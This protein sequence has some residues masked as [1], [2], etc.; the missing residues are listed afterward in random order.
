MKYPS[1]SA[2]QFV[3]L[4]LLLSPF[5]SCLKEE[6]SANLPVSNIPEIALLSVSPAAVHNL[7]DSLL[8]TMSYIDGDGDLGDYDVDSLSLWIT[9]NRFPLTEKFHI[10][11]LAPQGASIVITGELK[12]VLEHIILKDQSSVAEAATFTVQLKDRAGHWSNS[13]TSDTIMVLP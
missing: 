4:L 9:D 3:C 12:V 6:S 13:V 5:I 1:Q 10:I 7:Q 8:F 2:L 11:P